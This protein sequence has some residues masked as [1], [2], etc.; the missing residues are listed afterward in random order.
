MIE[1]RGKDEP[2]VARGSLDLVAFGASKR[3]HDA[4][5]KKIAVEAS[6]DFTS[7]FR[8]PDGR[9]VAVSHFDFRRVVW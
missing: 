9:R 8:D 5:A 1:L 4:L 2:D 3:A 7:Y 6:T